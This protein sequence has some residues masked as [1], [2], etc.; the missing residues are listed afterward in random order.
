[1]VDDRETNRHMV[2]TLMSSWGCR[3]TQVANGTAALALLRQAGN[4]W[5]L[6]Y[7]LYMRGYAAAIEGDL[8][9]AGEAYE[10]SIALCREV[11]NTWILS[12]VLNSLGDAS[13]MMGDYAR[14]GEVY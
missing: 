6:A 10:E 2:T 8:A 3:C 4:K 5:D 7:G 9:A 12:H 11:G 13:R 14:A 1:M